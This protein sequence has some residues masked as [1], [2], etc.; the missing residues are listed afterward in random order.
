MY[1]SAGQH[2]LDGHMALFYARTR[3]SDNDYNRMQ[4]QQDVLL[5]LRKQLDPCS[6]VLRLPE[7]L[8]IVRTRCGPTS[9]ST[10]FPTCWPSARG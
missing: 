1:L 7:L 2:H 3:H 10:P 8:D 5:A 9:R 4:R 6:L